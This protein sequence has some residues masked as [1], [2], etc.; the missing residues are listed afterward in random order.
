MGKNKLPYIFIFDI[1]N[2]I[3]GNVEYPIYEYEL[4]QLIK[5]N[6]NKKDVLKKC[7]KYIDIVK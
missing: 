7:K 3:I 2:C 5:N 6:C 1:D 4:M